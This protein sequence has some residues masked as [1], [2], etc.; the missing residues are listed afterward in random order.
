M[1]MDAEVE[2][3]QLENALV[4][5]TNKKAQCQK[6]IETL[7]EVAILSI[8]EEILSKPSSDYCD[9]PGTI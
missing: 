2:H 1:N 3:P 6:S 9:I 8:R 4:C 5:L 7:Q